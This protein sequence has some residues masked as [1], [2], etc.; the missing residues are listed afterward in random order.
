MTQQTLFRSSV[1]TKLPTYVP[2]SG[3]PLSEEE[4]QAIRKLCVQAVFSV[5]NRERRPA[6]LS[7]IFAFVRSKMLDP[8]YPFSVRSK[9]TVDRRVNEAASPDFYADNVAK[10]ACVSPGI[11]QPNP[12]LFEGKP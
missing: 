3:A 9:R 6:S 1:T 2:P 7:E 4:Q 12:K 8:S 10:I 11:Y 5:W